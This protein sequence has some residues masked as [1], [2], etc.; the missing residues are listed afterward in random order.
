MNVTIIGAGNMGRAIGRRAVSG[1]NQVEILDSDPA[2]A[3]RLAAELGDTATALGP[4]DSFGGDVVV[5]ALYYPGIKDAVREY[6][7]RLAGTVVVD[8]TNPGDTET[9]DRLATSPGKSSADEVAELVPEGTPVVK[10]FNTTFA[11]TLVARE[12]DGQQLDVLI[13]GDDERAKGKVSELVSSAGLRPVDVGPLARAEDLEHLGLLHI[14]LQQP[15]ELG[16]ASTFKL[17]P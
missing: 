15:R 8:I 17:H 10:A 12:V 5:F 1:G 4:D 14:T 3:R 9:W 2:E 13:A 16:F 7:D 11:P 6:G